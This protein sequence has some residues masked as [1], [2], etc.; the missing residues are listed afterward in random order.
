MSSKHTTKAPHIR[1]MRNPRKSTV[2]LAFV[3][4]VGLLGALFLARSDAATFVAAVEAESGTITGNATLVS[5]TTASNGKTVKFATPVQSNKTVKLMPLGDSITQGVGDSNLG[6]YR[7]QLWKK[8]VSQDAKKVDFVGSLANGGS[9]LGDKNHEG[10]SG[11]RIDQ[12]R[13]QIDGWS[14]SYKP[15]LVLLHIGTNDLNQNYSVSAAPTRL[16]DLVNR[17]CADVPGVEIIVASI[18][19]INGKDS[20]VNTYNS[21]IPG[22]VTAVKNTGCKASF[23]DMHSYITTSDLGDGVHP[24]VSGYNKMAEAWYPVASAAYNRIIAN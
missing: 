24:T 3:A 2:I 11:W 7:T 1:D 16:Q 22:V 23:F 18:I 5:D 13:A 8:L 21:A 20:Q 14:S 17:I 4:I 10:H 15:D 9:D 19:P 12:L 6:G